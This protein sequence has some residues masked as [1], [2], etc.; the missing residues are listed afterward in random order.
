[1]FR[2]CD[3]THC[4]IQDNIQQ[5]IENT[6]CAAHANPV[7]SQTQL[8]P[9]APQEEVQSVICDCGTVDCRYQKVDIAKAEAEFPVIFL[10]EADA[11][12]S[13]ESGA[14]RMIPVTHELVSIALDNRMLMRHKRPVEILFGHLHMSAQYFAILMSECRTHKEVPPADTSHP[15][16]HEEYSSVYAIYPS[17]W[18]WRGVSHD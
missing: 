8:P 18:Q 7:P 5:H 10:Q 17:H 16:H 6:A 3:G 13:K 12:L 15:P 14:S 4:S 1:M 9:L 2:E 11:G